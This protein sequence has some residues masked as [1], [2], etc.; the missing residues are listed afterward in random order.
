M[1]RIRLPDR[2]RRNHDERVERHSLEDI[3]EAL[4]S[5]PPPRINWKERSLKALPW[6]VLFLMVGTTSGK[7]NKI[8]DRYKGD[9]TPVLV[10]VGPN[11]VPVLAKQSEEGALNDEN[12]KSFLALC[13]PLLNRASS[14]LPEEAG[15][16]L[17]PGVAISSKLKIPTSIEMARSCLAPSI[18]SSYLEAKA[19]LL[20]K[21]LWKGANQAL[22]AVRV[23][24][25]TKTPGKP[26]LRDVIVTGQLA[27]ENPDRSP[28]SVQ[29]WARTFTVRAV[30][31]PQYVLKPTALEEKYNFF[32]KRRL[33]IF[34]I[35][36]AKEVLP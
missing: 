16:G 10:Q 25:V 12:V 31:K 29:Q 21:D 35:D 1:R 15:G 18:Q 4:N 27:T 7:V 13:V 8:Y 6:V 23:G 33:E 26:S 2:T 36:D 5:P 32:R 24:E 30:Q 34:Q 9:D 3:R 14:Q 22:I 28:R 20:P 11:G 17:D 19:V